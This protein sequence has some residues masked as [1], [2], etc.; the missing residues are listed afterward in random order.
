M[1]ESDPNPSL[2]LSL[3]AL[4]GLNYVPWSRVV[5]LS[6][7]G[8]RKFGYT[9]G[10]SVI[11]TFS[12]NLGYLKKLWD[13][14]NMYRPFTV[15]PI[16]LQQRVEEDKNIFL[17]SSLKPEYENLRS[18]I[19]MALKL[20]SFFIVCQTIQ[21]EETRKKIMN[22]DVKVTYEKPESHALVAEKK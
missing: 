17:L 20:P 18:N 12:E 5:T 10:N 4:N 9:N 2:K 6:L 22:A 7:G 16:V 11:K 14:L 8:I 1:V 13:E 3:V 15:N 19:L 21:R